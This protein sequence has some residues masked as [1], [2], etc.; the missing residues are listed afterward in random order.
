MTFQWRKNG[1]DLQGATDSS[2]TINPARPDDGGSYDVVVT[3][4][5][6]SVTSTAAV[7]TVIPDL[8][9]PNFLSAI[10]QTNLSEIVLTF[11]ERLSVDNAEDVGNYNVSLV[12]G[13][14]ALTINSATVTNG[15]N[16]VLNT[17]PRVQGPGYT[18][19]LGN[20]TDT[21]EALNLATPLTRPIAFTQILLTP[22]DVTLWRFNTASN[23]LDGVGWQLPGFDD[24]AWNTGFAGFTTSNNLEITTN[25]FELRTTNMIAPVSGGPITAYY[26]VPF[27]FP[28]S[29]AGA[30]LRLVGVVDD[31]LVAYINGVEA[32]RL[33]VTNASPVSFNH[34]ATASSPEA[35]DVHLPLETIILTNLSGLVSGNNLL[36]LELHQNSAT[37]SDAVLSVQ[38]LGEIMEVGGTPRLQVSRNL[39][40]G[41]IT[42]SWSGP[43][44]LQHSSEL[45]ITGTQWTAVPG[46]PNPYTF[47]PTGEKRFFRLGP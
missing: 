39:A 31:G 32:G 14:G 13:G 4:G 1:V 25:G 2:Y 22:D 33:R 15:T 9:G 37:S 16:V 38:L 41:E 8:T 45:L 19:V 5:E 23:N 36:A 44:V 28:A 40:T 26:R 27:N 20:I 17:S 11:S 34:L 35:S 47:M 43:G 6:G 24:A 10:G 18:I 30:G 46:N 21:S 12:G 7:L 29:T 3:N 42:V